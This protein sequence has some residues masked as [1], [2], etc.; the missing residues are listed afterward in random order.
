MQRGMAAVVVGALAVAACGSSGGG[1]S[2]EAFCGLLRQFQEQEGQFE[3]VLEDPEQL[4]RA[5]DAVDELAD[6]A[7]S[8]IRDDAQT[9]ADGFGEIARAFSDVDA[10]DPAAAL[11]AVQFADVEEASE[12][13]GEYAEEN[14]DLDLSEGEG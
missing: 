11:E 2:V 14:C 6:A 12:N 1:G 8:E 10:D 7:P 9:V 13:L 3:N 4:Q 5:V